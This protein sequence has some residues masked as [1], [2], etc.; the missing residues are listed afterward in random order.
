MNAFLTHLPTPAQKAAAEMLFRQYAPLGEAGH[1]VRG[2]LEDCFT[3]RHANSKVY[4]ALIGALVAHSADAR[5][6]AEI[7]ITTPAPV[8]L[9]NFNNVEI[10][11]H[12]ICEPNPGG[13]LAYG[14][15]VLDP[16]PHGDT[17]G[18]IY[19]ESGAYNPAPHHTNFASAYMAIGKALAWLEGRRH[20]YPALV[21][22]PLVGVVTGLTTRKNNSDKWARMH[23]R[24]IELLELT[25]SSAEWTGKSNPRIQQADQLARRA[26]RMRG[27]A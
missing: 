20:L 1:I 22:N 6:Y 13:V 11:C 15:V 9:D 23:N 21:H 18:I 24:C 3:N 4:S 8:L 5:A 17:D 27:A 19:Q 14:F 16:P 2:V 25:G 12:G 10:Y 26:A 7:L